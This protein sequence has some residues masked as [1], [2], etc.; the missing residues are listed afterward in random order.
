[1]MNA[2]VEEVAQ[3][4]PASNAVGL[5]TT[6]LPFFSRLVAP[7][8]KRGEVGALVALL[9]AFGWNRVTVLSTDTLFA[10]DFAAEFTRL[11]I[12][13]H[14]DESGRWEGEIKKSHT[15]RTEDDGTIELEAIRQAL[16][17]EDNPSVNSRVI[18]LAAHVEH[19]F[20]VLEEAYMSGYPD[21]TI[22]VGPSTWV[23]REPPRVYKLPQLPGYLGVGLYRNRNEDYQNFLSDYKIWLRGRN[24]DVLDELPDFAAETVDSIV[25]LTA[26]IASTPIENRSG[27]A[28]VQTLRQLDFRGVS[29]RVIFT[30]EGNRKDPVYTIFNAQLQENGGALEWTDVGSALVSELGNVTINT[31]K[32]TICFAEVGCNPEVVPQDE[33]PMPTYSLPRWVIAVIVVFGFLCCVLAFIYCRSRVEKNRIKAEFEAFRG[34]LVGLRTAEYDYIPQV[35][36]DIECGVESSSLTGT[37]SCHS[38]VSVQWCWQESD[39]FM[40]SHDASEIYGDPANR[41]IKYPNACSDSLEDAFQAG[42]AELSPVPGLP[43]YK[44]IFKKMEQIK[45]ATKFTRPVKRVFETNEVDV[46]KIQSG[47]PLPS[48]LVGEPQM[49][50]IRGDIVQIQTKRD[51]CWAF[52]SK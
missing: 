3:L 32:E 50:L 17:W 49:V 45:L 34:S 41:W 42:K 36:K 47:V 52:G 10:S 5:T 15:I 28:V 38:V 6:Q 13:Q 18:V 46:G 19:A 11:W 40:D 8:D 9:R 48:D 27:A 23:G 24:K 14:I 44:V 21:D 16:K 43:G 29:G 4:S 37:A 26:A 31:T 22:W 30:K 25:A 35:P 12:G 7:N 51:D 1:M 33:Y 39:G 2:G 20:E